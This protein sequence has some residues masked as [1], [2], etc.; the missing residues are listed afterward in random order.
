M[1]Y[2][3][4]SDDDEDESHQTEFESENMDTSAIV[5]VHPQSELSHALP[6]PCVSF[7]WYAYLYTRNIARERRYS[8]TVDT[9]DEGNFTFIDRSRVEGNLEENT[10]IP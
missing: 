7:E 3:H 10:Y 1:T 2:S 6:I 5:I 9:D 8:N 4:C